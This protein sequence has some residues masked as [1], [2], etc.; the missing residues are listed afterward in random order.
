MPGWQEVIEGTTIDDVIHVKPQLPRLQP[1]LPQPQLPQPQPPLPRPPQQPRPPLP[2]RPPQQLPPPQPPPLPSTTPQPASPIARRPSH[3]ALPR[4]STTQ[5]STPSRTVCSRRA[6]TAVPRRQSSSRAADGVE[7]SPTVTRLPRSRRCT[8][9][10]DS[11]LPTPQ[12]STATTTCSRQPRQPPPRQPPRQQPPLSCAPPTLRRP[13]SPPSRTT[14]LSAGTLTPITKCAALPSTPPRLRHLA[15]CFQTRP[16]S[17][18]RA[19]LAPT[20]S[21]QTQTLVTATR[22]L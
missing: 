4:T 12:T 3:H 13:V 22:L 18:S 21:L 6:T 16:C 7:T 14:C 8:S 11:A 5:T 9:A 20:S 1:P 17:G 19:T 10:G 15:M 2:P